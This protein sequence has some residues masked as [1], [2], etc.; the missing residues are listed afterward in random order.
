M[1]KNR[2]EATVYHTIRR[3]K[4]ASLSWISLL[5]ETVSVTGVSRFLAPLTIAIPVLTAMWEASAISNSVLIT[6]TIAVAV[7][8]VLYWAASISREGKDRYAF[9][10]RSLPS[11]TVQALNEAK[12]SVYQESVGYRMASFDGRMFLHSPKMDRYIQQGGLEKNWEYSSFKYRLPSTL[13]QFKYLNLRRHYAKGRAMF[14]GKLLGLACDPDENSAV[15]QVHPIGYFDHITSN[16]VVDNLYFT[17]GYEELLYDGNDLIMNPNTGQL[18]NLIESNAANV[19]GSSTLVITKD[20]FLIIGWQ[21]SMSDNSRNSLI[22]SGSG[23]VSLLDGRY[24][25]TFADILSTAAERE[26][27]EEAAVPGTR[28]Y[29]RKL[30]TSFPALYRSSIELPVPIVTKPIGFLRD[31]TRAGLPDYFCLSY[32]DLPADQ[33]IGRKE[34]REEKGLQKGMHCVE[35]GASESV[36]DA[37]LRA[38]GDA[39]AEK[40]AISMQLLAIRD[41]LVNMQERGELLDFVARLEREA[42][43]MV[44]GGR[45]AKP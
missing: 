36:A 35:I 38:I 6:V 42:T 12:L 11:R 14:N 7:V 23:S 27:F 21:G 5:V 8:V 29:L 4:G 19:I 20:G 28:R 43:K 25:E 18:V 45:V 15:I 24:S 34:F 44:D 16:L 33:A 39:E 26:Y 10:V 1:Q 41:I 40:C 2:E 30:S 31:L 3:W 13:Q 32:L 9:A 17:P 22:P 37:L